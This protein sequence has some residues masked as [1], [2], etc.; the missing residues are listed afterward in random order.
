[1]KVVP[2]HLVATVKALAKEFFKEGATE[3]YV[4]WSG[5][6]VYVGREPAVKFRDR[7]GTPENVRLTEAEWQSE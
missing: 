3:V 4:A 7:E 2:E 5:D 1:M 6:R